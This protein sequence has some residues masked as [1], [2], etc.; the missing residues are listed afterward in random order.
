MITMFRALYATAITLLVLLAAGC[1]D[2]PVRARKPAP[3]GAQAV[4]TTTDFSSGALSSVR[5]DNHAASIGVAP[6]H[7]D[8][9]VRV[10]GGLVYVVN[11]FGDGG[12]NIQIHDPADN[13]ALVRQFSV[14]NGSDP[15]DIAV[16]SDDKAYVT[17]YNSTEWWIVNPETGDHIGTV[18]FSSLS[19][20][21]GIPEMDRMVVVGNTLFV[22]VQ[23]MDRSGFPWVTTDASYVAIVDTDV[24]SLI[25]AD[26]GTPGTQPIT[27]TN[28]NPYST[29]QV[30]DVTDNLYV[31]CV[32]DWGVNDAGVEWVL[33]G[34]LT[35]GATI[36]AGAAAA[37]DITDVEIVSLERGYAIVTDAAFATT[38]IAFDPQSGAVVDTVYAPGAFTLQ[39]VE[40]APDGDLFLT[41]RDA[42]A[43]GLRIYDAA[44]GAE[45][46][47]A[48]IDVGLPPFDIDFWE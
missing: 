44:T 21:D 1:E 35:S 39:D 16:V 26:A 3:T 22:T 5:L 4:V 29:L 45:K 46:T 24:D 6:T 43:P 7:S 8:A 18:D 19:D 2:D 13:F 32:G 20:A 47:T 17:R 10:F 27:L 28:K 30:D 48:P 15:H 25:D 36:L 12:N 14:E 9:V 23:R 33:P 42:T 31:A 38:L 11:R 40:A 41:D 34:A 37:G